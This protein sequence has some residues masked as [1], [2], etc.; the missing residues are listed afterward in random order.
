MEFPEDQ[1]VLASA[2]AGN[3]TAV[4]DIA[5]IESFELFPNPVIDR[6]VQLKLKLKD[7]REIRY[8]LYNLKGQFL[9]QQN[10]GNQAGTLK[11]SVPTA[12]LQSG[13]Y[14]IKVN[15]GEQSFAKRFIKQ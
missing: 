7:S 14:F 6:D 13:T 9:W 4:E 11:T 15:I 1:Q 5:A 12:G 8:E 3:L 2:E 10:Q